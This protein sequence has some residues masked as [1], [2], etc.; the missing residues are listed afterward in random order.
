MP[1]TVADSDLVVNPESIDDDYIHV[2]AGIIWHRDD[3]DRFLIARRQK[4]KHLQDLWE[5]PGGKLEPGETP[6]NALVRELSEEIAIT[7]EQGA[8]FMQVYCRYPERNV[9]LDIWTVSE[10]RGEVSPA[11]QQAL[12]WISIDEAGHYE[13]P[14]ADFPVLE[15]IR[16]SATTGTR[17]SP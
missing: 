12:R 7:A 14:A 6:W 5:F 13:W 15:A 8:A 3:N 16:N 1:N 17:Y 9:L 2:L 4:G 11:E 10:Y